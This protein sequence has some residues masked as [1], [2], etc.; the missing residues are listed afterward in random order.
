MAVKNDADAAD[1]DDVKDAGM[2]S[3][4][5]M[6]LRDLGIIPSNWPGLACVAGRTVRCSSCDGTCSDECPWLSPD[7][8]RLG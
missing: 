1:V 8:A 4:G 6:T 5:E 2:D 3:V 7:W